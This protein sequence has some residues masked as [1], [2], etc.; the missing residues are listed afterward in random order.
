MSAATRVRPNPVS[1]P[2]LALLALHL[3]ASPLYAQPH[4][5]ETQGDPLSAGAQAYRAGDFETTIALWRPLAEAGDRDAQFAL[6]T[7]YQAGHGVAQSDHKAT[8]W[9]QRAAEQGSVPAQFNLGNAYMHGRGVAI[10]EQQ[11]L[12]WWMKAAEAG[13]APAQFNVGTAYLYGRG[14]APSVERALD[15]YRMAAANGHAGAQAALQRLADQAQ[16]YV[17][18]GPSW[19]R[20]RPAHHFT[21]QLLAAESKEQAEDYV[22]SLPPGEYAVC[23][24]YSQD[25]RWFAVLAGSYSDSATAQ[26][27][28]DQWPGPSPPWVRRFGALQERL[29]R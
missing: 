13:L 9:F 6:G 11:A 19:V 14:T 22:A 3:C 15:W 26:A 1:W 27:A 12:H 21:L 2:W 8:E 20:A 7:L 18:H 23:A 5:A 28:A 29:A 25:R 16:S 24:Y 10:D 4:A 17:L